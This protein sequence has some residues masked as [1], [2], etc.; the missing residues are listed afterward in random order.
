MRRKSWNLIVGSM[1]IV[2]LMLMNASPATSVTKSNVE[3]LTFSATTVEGKNFKSNVLLG[4]KPSVLW[5]WAP[6]CAICKNESRFIVSAASKYKNKVNFIGV[7]ALGSVAEMQDFVL[8][9]GTRSFINLND[10]STKIWSRF[11]VFIQ[12]TLVFVDSAGRITSKVGPSS[13][14]YL[15]KKLL[16][17]T[18]S[19]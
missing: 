9:T 5:F 13:P 12:P 8:H 15:N 7:G 4:K 2:F 16:A 6:W 17:L 1:A 11:G 10:E 3:K 14:E 19:Q 18:S